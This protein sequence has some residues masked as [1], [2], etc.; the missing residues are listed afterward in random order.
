MTSASNNPLYLWCGHLSIS[1]KINAVEGLIHAEM[2]VALE[3]LSHLLGLHFYFEVHSPYITEL[4]G[5]VSEPAIIQPVERMAVVRTSSLEHMCIVGVISWESP[6]K[7]LQAY[8]HV[9]ID[10]VSAEE[11]VYF[12]TRGENTNCSETVSQLLG[13]NVAILILIEDRESIFEVHVWLE[14]QSYFSN[15]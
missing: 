11:K 8:S 2:G 3:S 15:L 4:N 13:G 6:S 14:R 12:F 10:I 7:L 1:V 5:S 9:P